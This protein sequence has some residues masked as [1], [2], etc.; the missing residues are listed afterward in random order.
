MTVNG[1]AR[2][3][4]VTRPDPKPAKAPMLLLL[5]PRDTAPELTANFTYVADFVATQNFWAV[6]P[7]ALDGAWKAEPLEGTDDKDFMSAL[8]DTL[9]ADGV[10]PD[11]V[12]VA[13]YSNG[14]VMAERM[15]CEMSDRIAAVG[16]VAATLPLSL[17]LSC[18]PVASRPKL[19][20]LGKD[21]PI[22]PYNGVAGLGSAMA[23]MDYWA[24]KQG[25]DGAVST[26]LP[27]SA[28]DGT[29]VQLDERTGCTDDKALR[30][31]SVENGGHTWPGGDTSYVGVTS[32]DMS[33]TGVI[34]SFA[35]GYRRQ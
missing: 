18:A 17:W 11:R 10:D 15:A 33:A 26:P 23:L 3:Y 35:S 32:R 25:C 6:M 9:V 20:V 19:Y 27:D 8:I 34:W 16:V 2:R 31:Y 22:V 21:D 14:G 28:D 4:V 13:G 7:E 29:T 30:L 12:S 5:H 24:T 1:Q